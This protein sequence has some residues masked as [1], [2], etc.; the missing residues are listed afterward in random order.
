MAL[1]EHV[2]APLRRCHVPFALMGWGVL[3]GLMVYATVS[4]IAKMATV[5]MI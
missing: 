2:Y 3:I 1:G 4:D 5:V